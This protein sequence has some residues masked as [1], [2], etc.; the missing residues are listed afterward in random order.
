MLCHS[1]RSWNLPL[2]SL[3]RSVVAKLNLATGTP[4]VVNLMSGSLPRFPT[5]DHLVYTFRRHFPSLQRL[6]MENSG[7]AQHCSSCKG[8][9]RGWFS[10][11]DA[12]GCRW[13]PRMVSRK[14]RLMSR[15][16]DELIDGASLRERLFSRTG[17]SL[18]NR[19][20]FRSFTIICHDCI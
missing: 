18:A 10:R 2:S 15:E 7:F 9:I 12:P 16:R 14:K 17:N 4:L 1:V 13:T 3:N 6:T 19:G 11:W 20:R 5:K 8:A